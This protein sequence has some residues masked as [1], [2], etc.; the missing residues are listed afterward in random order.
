MIAPLFRP[1]RAF[2]SCTVLGLL[3]AALVACALV[4]A[5]A[6][7]PAPGLARLHACT[8]D[9]GPADALCGTLPVFEDRARG[10]GRQIP[11]AIVVLPA[12]SDDYRPDPFVLLAGGPGQGAASLA[13]FVSATFARIQRHR[14]IVLVDQRGTGRSHPLDCD[15]PR[16]SLRELFADEAAGLARLRR[17]LERLD[18]DPRLYTTTLAM[19]DLDDVRTY[20]GYDRL[21]LYGASYGTRAALVYLRQHRAHVRSMVL[22]GVAPPDMRL[23]LYTARDAS[24]ALDALLADCDARP[25]CRGAFPTLRD[26]VRTLL[27]RLE[28]APARVSLAHPRTGIRE[29]VDVTARGVASILFGALYSPVT[30]SLVPLV[31]ERA[32]QDDFQGLIAL[33]FAGED[34]GDVSVG[35]QLS[36]LCAEDASRIQDEDFEAATAGTLFGRHLMSGQRAA[37]GIWPRGTVPPDY[38]DPVKSDV[39]TLILSGEIDPITPPSWGELV[40]QHLTRARHLVAPATGHGVAASH[41]GTTIVAA[42]LERGSPDVDAGC[43]DENARP[44]YFLSPSG[45]DPLAAARGVSP[46]RPGRGTN[47][48]ATSSR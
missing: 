6:P 41:C 43:L 8:G 9:E 16:E 7:S 33:G 21:N 37:C 10:A 26:G 40:A 42:F 19:D 28:Q 3:A 31:V 15:E 2:P 14:D 1:R 23:P 36:V 48:P 30:A 17:C 18:A 32:A 46:E 11:L 39:P 45:P 25:A 35:M 4:A 24:R 13:P 34:G 5:C 27:A 38:F 22:D 44:P 47:L 12:T 29:T 20:L